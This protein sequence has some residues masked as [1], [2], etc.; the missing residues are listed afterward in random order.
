MKVRRESGASGLVTFGRRFE[1]AGERAFDIAHE[2]QRDS[3]RFWG[4]PCAKS[5]G[6]AFPCAFLVDPPRARRAST[7]RRKRSVDTV[8]KLL[9][10]VH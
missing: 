3:I 6:T 2:I 1:T 7:R 10:V 8:G 5:L 9:L 4:D